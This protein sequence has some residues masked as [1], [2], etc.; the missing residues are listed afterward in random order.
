METPTA[1]FLFLILLVVSLALVACCL[2]L[3]VWWWQK[4]MRERRAELNEHRRQTAVA[5][6]KSRPSAQNPL[7]GRNESKEVV[8]STVV[9][10]A[11][12]GQQ[13]SSGWEG[14][15]HVPSKK[16]KKR[17][18]SSPPRK[19]H[20]NDY[21]NDKS[22]PPPTRADPALPGQVEDRE[23]PVSTPLR[24]PGVQ[25][26]PDSRQYKSPPSASLPPYPAYHTAPPDEPT[27]YDYYPPEETDTKHHKEKKKHHRHHHGK[28][29]KK[30]HSSHKSKKH[31]K[32]HHG[33]SSDEYAS[34]SPE[35][36]Y[37]ILADNNPSTVVPPPPAGVGPASTLSPEQR[38]QLLDQVLANPANPTLLLSS[39]FYHGS[40]MKTAF[41]QQQQPPSTQ[42]AP[43]DPTSAYH[44]VGIPTGDSPTPPPPPSFMAG[45]LHDTF[46]QYLQSWEKEKQ[47]RKEHKRPTHVED[48]RQAKLRAQWEKQQTAS[49]TSFMSSQASFLSSTLSK[50]DNAP[51]AFIRP[52]FGDMAYMHLHVDNQALASQV[53]MRRKQL[54]AKENAMLE[55]ELLDQIMYLQRLQNAP[56]ESSSEEASSDG[57]TDYDS[58]DYSGNDQ[59]QHQQQQA[60]T[61]TP[62]LNNQPTTTGKSVE[63]VTLQQLM[64]EHPNV[65]DQPPTHVTSTSGGHTN[66]A[67]STTVPSGTTRDS[68]SGGSGDTGGAG[69]KSGQSTSSWWQKTPLGS[70]VAI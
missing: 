27:P 10:D 6:D 57:G 29:K 13:D 24:N 62:P 14:Y 70:E 58:G 9:K 7:R 65:P 25:D 12:T 48:A 31:K 37:D 46:R 36:D 53:E 38:K 47:E 35:T 52:A 5:S 64:P 68:R 15:K 4:R 51:N 42:E 43:E 17:R 18:T 28:K 26:R 3:C 34:D 8:V 56:V 32:R 55:E 61:T 21:H 33:H 59:E 54:K 50:D 16:E 23:A 63:S 30:K 49:H 22:A 41:E 45:N 60:K 66:T 11:E 40:P 39:L 20:H 69:P 1:I 19:D 2:G 67:K 44:N